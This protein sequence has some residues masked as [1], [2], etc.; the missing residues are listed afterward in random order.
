[1]IVAAA[2][3]SVPPPLTEQLVPGGRLVQPIGPG[4]EDDVTLFE[5][6]DAGLARVRTIVPAHFVRLY[7]RHGY[8]RTHR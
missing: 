4:G 5:R 6:R 3:E 8:P 1:V 2:F 7:G